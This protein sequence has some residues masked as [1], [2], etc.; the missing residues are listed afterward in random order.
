MDLIL[1]YRHSFHQSLNNNQLNT[2]MYLGISLG[3]SQVE[4]VHKYSQLNLILQV[5]P[6]V[7]GHS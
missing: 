7:L 1:E 3:T 5:A 2:Q 6:Q 4:T